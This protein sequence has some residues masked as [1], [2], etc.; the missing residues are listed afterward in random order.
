M[1]LRIFK[2]P[3][4]GQHIITG[5]AFAVTDKY[6]TLTKPFCPEWIMMGKIIT[7]LSMLQNASLEAASYTH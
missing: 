1:C 2:L 7:I 4:H 3:Q 5:V 6:M